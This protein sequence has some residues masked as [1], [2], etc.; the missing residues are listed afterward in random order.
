MT[1][2]VVRQT[3]DY[4]KFN[5]IGEN[6]NIKSAHVKRIARSFK[7]H[8][9]LIN[10]ILVNS[11]MEV[12]DGQHR[13]A[14]AR[15]IS[16]PIYY[17]E[18]GDYDIEEVQALNLNQRNWTK[19][20]YAQSYASMGYED[21]QML[22]EFDKE[23]KEFPFTI[24]IKLLQNSNAARYIHQKE[25]AAKQ[26]KSG[27]SNQKQV[28]EEG[29]WQVEDFETAVEWAEYLR[30]IGEYYEGYKRASFVSAIITLMKKKQFDADEF[31][32]KLSYQSN[33]L[34]D[35]ASVGDYIMLIE[36]IYNFKKR[37]K[38]NLRY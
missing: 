16:K 14:A 6:R 18:V 30:D 27:E 19:R 37:N 23:Y 32:R 34:S 22:L 10:P 28:F 13:L 5:I 25:Y 1:D 24:C 12:V 3:D 9:I 2:I 7:D 4:D 21:Y 20:D 17:I 38:I 11:D 31:I 35:C 36:E 8:G 15:K 29:T 33:A 26:N